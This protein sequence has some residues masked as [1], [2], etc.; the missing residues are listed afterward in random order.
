MGSTPGQTDWLTASPRPSQ[1]HFRAAVSVPSLVVGGPA[2]SVTSGLKWVPRA[3]AMP[4][5]GHIDVGGC[6]IFVI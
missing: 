6:S 3:L 1:S 4:V 2:D 5:Y